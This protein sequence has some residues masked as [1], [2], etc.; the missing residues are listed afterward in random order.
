MEKDLFFYTEL[1]IEDGMP[2]D[3]VSWIDGM[4]A[5]EFISGWGNTVEI[6]PEQLAQYAFNTNVN[7]EATV[8][9][10]GE[11]VGL[12]IDEINH[13]YGKAAGWITEVRLSDN[14]RNII[15]FGV[16]WTDLG[17]E[18]I[19]SGQ[20]RYFSPTFN[21]DQL[22]IVGGSL[23]NW[24]ATREKNERMLLQPITLSQTLYQV[25]EK[26]AVVAFIEGK[27]DEL[28]TALGLNRREN[29]ND[30]L[31]TERKPMDELLETPEVI[32]EIE[33]LSEAR[34]EEL[35]NEKAEKLT[36]QRVAEALALQERQAHVAEYAAR[37]VGASGEAGGL[38]V[39]QG[40]LS[41]FML[42]LSEEQQG[43]FEGILDQVL[44]LK[45]IDFTEHGHGKQI[46]GKQP[47]PDT[48]KQQL[49]S[50]LLA[51]SGTI[52]EWFAL[53]A[54]MLGNM[55]DYDLTQFKED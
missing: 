1:A 5:G 21:R 55:E 29:N 42:S 11:V 12:P 26:N 15:E 27:F 33:R 52:A 4:A 38:A 49:A 2:E 46:L 13:N 18:L 43:Q 54:D 22:A 39:D 25:H 16:R 24:P 35:A 40:S 41:T 31:H 7:I 53:N 36:E 10:N 44:K 20:L 51:K 30:P 17:R 32:A 3:G 34:A 50:W 45:L 48:M 9:A 23:T 19:S 6:K 14:R 8:D 28:I 37:V 47:L